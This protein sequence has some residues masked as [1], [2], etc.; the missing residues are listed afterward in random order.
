M[1]PNLTVVF[2]DETVA[3]ARLAA[4]DHSLDLA[5]LEIGTSD[6]DDTPAPVPYAE[7]AELG[8]GRLVAVA[9]PSGFRP[10]AGMIAAGPVR[11]PPV[12]GS[13]PVL[14]DD[15]EGGVAVARIFEEFFLPG[16]QPGFPLRVGDIITHV[17]GAPT[18]DLEG[19]IRRFEDWPPTGDR[20]R[21]AGEPV[22]V[23]YLRGGVP[24]E[25][26]FPLSLSRNPV[27]LVRA[28]SHRAGGFPKA[29]V[30]QFHRSR[31]EHCGSPVVDAGGRVVG[32][33]IAKSETV[34][35]LVLPVDEVM[36]SLRR[37][38]SVAGGK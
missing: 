27:H 10:L 21:I 19:W 35:D 16:Q 18:P 5:L 28:S 38:E 4:V 9:P 13:I 30:A 26:T 2:E 24:G 20:P 8:R 6:V 11:V 12:E 31:P 37:L 3:H 33:L 25:A 36:Q 32:I 14:V 7:P 1:R 34:E 23:R 29:F 17:H 15:G 22:T